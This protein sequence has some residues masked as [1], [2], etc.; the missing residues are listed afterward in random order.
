VACL[1]WAYFVD[2]SE[3]VERAPSMAAPEQRSRLAIEEFFYAHVPM[4]LGVVFIAAGESNAIGHATEA[5]ATASRPRWKAGC[6]SIRRVTWR[7]GGRSRLGV[8]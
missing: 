3:R 5:L 8:A 4:L 6:S 1:W 7:S 2:D